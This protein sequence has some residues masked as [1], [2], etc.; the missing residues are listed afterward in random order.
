M[1][2]FFLTQV[3]EVYDFTYSNQ[4][5]ADDENLYHGVPGDIEIRDS[6]SQIEH[7]VLPEWVHRN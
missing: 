5:V 1:V 3:V 6:C 2:V 4:A 7:A